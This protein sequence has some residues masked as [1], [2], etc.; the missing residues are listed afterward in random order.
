MTLAK[1]CAV[2]FVSFRRTMQSWRGWM[3]HSP[4]TLWTWFANVMPSSTNTPR[5]S[6]QSTG[7]TMVPDSKH[8]SISLFPHSNHNPTTFSDTYI[9]LQDLSSI[10]TVDSCL[11]MGIWRSVSSGKKCLA[12]SPCWCHA[13]DEALLARHHLIS[14]FNLIINFESGK[15]G[16]KFGSHFYTNGSYENAIFCLNLV[17]DQL[18]FISEAGK[19]KLAAK[20]QVQ[21][22]FVWFQPISSY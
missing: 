2:S 4:A 12:S 11:S 21:Y 17:V 22:T 7:W 9:V 6:T 1:E 8:N 16:Y 14:L 13:L 18:K 3:K 5:S 19:S 20:C 15:L 10:F